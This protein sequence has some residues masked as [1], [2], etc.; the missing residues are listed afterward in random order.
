MEAIK[1][2]NDWDELLAKE[3]KQEYFQKLIE[4]LDKE[5][6]FEKVYPEHN[7]IFNAFKKTPFDKVEVVIVGQD[8]YFNLGE[9]NGLSFSVNDGVAL[10][11]TLKNIYRELYDDL[12]IEPVLSGNLEK[13][14]EQ[15]VLLLNSI[16]T[17]RDGC[18]DSHKNRGWEK[19]TDAVVY[20]IAHEKRNIVFVLWGNYAHKKEQNITNTENYIIKSTHPSGLS[21]S[22]KNEKIMPFFGSKPF[23]CINEYLARTGQTPIDWNLD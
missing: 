12:K 13:W 22:R 7:K 15:G 17:V 2:E 4:F 18:K 20:K 3:F 14:A 8:P 6:S 9:A 19:F 16:L 10:P 5:Y 1:I 21:S 23:S 11:P